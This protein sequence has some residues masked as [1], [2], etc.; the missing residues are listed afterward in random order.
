MK[1]NEKLIELRKKEGLSQEELGYK[2]NVTRQTVSQWE[3]GQTTPE[4]DKLA[5]MSKI[6]NISVDELINELEITSNQNQVIEDQQIGDTSS[7]NNKVVIIIVGLL[8]VVIV[9]ILIKMITGFTAF[10]KITEEQGLF[11]KFFSIFN[12]ATESQQNMLGDAEN[13]IGNTVNQLNITKFN[14]TLE[15]Y[16]G[17]NTGSSLE[18]FL[19]KVITTNK[20]KDRKITIKYMETET[21]DTEVIKKLKT[22]IDDNSNFEVSFEYDE[23]GY[24]Y[25]ALIERVFSQYEIRSFNS[26][27]ELYAGSTMGASVI[28]VLDDIITNNKTEDRIITVKHMETETQNEDEIKNIKHTI[29]KFDDY[30]LT[31][32]YDED[33]FI[34]KLTIEKI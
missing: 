19:E 16:N 11:D 32:E 17:S 6:F 5:E 28:S 8:I 25:E 27:F 10:N 7:K 14:S 20:T 4:M 1:F 15:M 29:E 2:L 31:F 18:S 3:L 22:S 34:Y 33:G 23:E 12:Q 9:W 30:E 24:I 26:S 13:M 21:Q